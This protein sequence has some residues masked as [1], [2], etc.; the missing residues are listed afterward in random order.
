M[1]LTLCA[2]AQ[3]LP[4]QHL[5]Q[6]VDE[7]GAPLAINSSDVN[8]YLREATG[9]DVTAKDFRTWAGT[10]LAAA[11]LAEMEPFTS[12]TSAKRN[13]RQVIAQ[14]AERLGNT[15]AVCRKCYIHPEISSAYL[16][17]AL[18]LEAAEERR[19]PVAWRAYEAAVLQFLR[20]RSPSA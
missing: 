5:F 9:A 12:G 6:Y 17:G 18:A 13:L 19:H 10:V 8:A 1:S 14:V 11:S 20:D 4:G 7:S 15:A 3:E 16:T 2:P